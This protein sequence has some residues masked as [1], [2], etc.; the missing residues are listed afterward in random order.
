MRLAA[1]ACGSSA[2][3][4]VGGSYADQVEVEGFRLVDR[5]VRAE[6]TVLVYV[7]PSGS[8][9]AA[10]VKAPGFDF[11]SSPPVAPT[12][13]LLF[14]CLAE[15]YRIPYRDMSCRLSVAQLKE[16]VA[17][18]DFLGLDADDTNA[19]KRGRSM[20]LELTIGCSQPG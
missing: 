5:Y 6:D 2:E 9:V 20:V 12:V 19:V 13:G 18:F 15:G 10:A 4:K 1:A 16:D 14:Q 8:D 11:G 3:E 7:R 17:S